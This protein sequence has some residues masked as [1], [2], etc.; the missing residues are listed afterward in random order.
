MDCARARVTSTCGQV[1]N[2]ATRRI[3]VTRCML[4]DIS[5]EGETKLERERVDSWLIAQECEVVLDDDDWTC[6]DGEFVNVL[7]SAFDCDGQCT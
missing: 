1:A 5:L 2:T 7:E 3:V 6:T 4:D